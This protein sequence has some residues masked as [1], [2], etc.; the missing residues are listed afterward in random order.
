MCLLQAPLTFDKNAVT[1][2]LLSMDAGMAGRSTAI[3]DALGLALKSVKDGEGKNNKVI[4]LLSDGENNDG[5][6]SI[7]QVIN[8][9]KNENIKIYT[10]GVGNS[11]NFIQSILSYKMKLPS[12]LDEAGLQAI[13]QEAGGQYFRAEDTSRLIDVYQAIDKL[14]PQSREKNYVQEIKEYYYIPLLIAFFLAVVLMILKRK[15][16]A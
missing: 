2:I 12:G 14:E 1:N 11:N 7:P 9:A 15:R 5:S 16:G 3:G 6:L 8:L 4:I 10:I 13:A